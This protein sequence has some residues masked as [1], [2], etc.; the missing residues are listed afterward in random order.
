MPGVPGDE[1]QIDELGEGLE[2]PGHR[3]AEGPSRA[4]VDLAD[5]VGG[6]GA[7]GVVAV[8]PVPREVAERDRGHLGQVRRVEP[9]RRDVGHDEG[10]VELAQHRRFRR[11]PGRQR[12]HIGRGPPDRLLGVEAQAVVLHHP[13]I[14]VEPVQHERPPHREIEQP[15]RCPG[16]D[17]HREPRPALEHGVDDLDRARGVPQPVTRDVVDEGAGAH[18]LAVGVGVGAGA[19][20]GAGSAAASTS[21]RVRAKTKVM[22]RRRSGGMSTRSGSFNAG[23]ITVLMPRRRAARAFSRMPPTGSTSPLSVISPVIATSS[24]TARPVAAERIAVAIVTPADGP[25]LGIAPAGTCTC[26]SRWWRN[27]GSTPSASA[28]ARM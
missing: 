14:G 18:T 12:V 20:A 28:S 10:S 1:R 19:G 2:P 13:G 3:Q 16:A 25:S 8:D 26:R 27:A 9:E 17:V 21:P 6:P 15:P 4:P 7:A 22:S 11:R 5:G 23:R 24:R